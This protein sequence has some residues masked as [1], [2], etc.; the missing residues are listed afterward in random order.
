MVVIR[1][2]LEAERSVTEKTMFGG[3]GFMLNGNFLCSIH[4]DRLILRVGLDQE[5]EALA[6]PPHAR[7]F[8]MTGKPMKG[9]IFVA[10]EAMATQPQLRQWLDTGK[11]FVKTLPRK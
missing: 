4:R 9:W 2:A 1:K 10:T 6:R 5:A 3:I 8:D 11:A 7:R